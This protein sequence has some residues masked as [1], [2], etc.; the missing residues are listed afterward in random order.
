MEVDKPNDSVAGAAEEADVKAEAVKLNPVEDVVAAAAE[1][2]DDTA[3]DNPPKH[4][5]MDSTAGLLVAG[6]A[7]AARRPDFAPSAAVE[8]AAGKLNEEAGSV[9]AAVDAGAADVAADDPNNVEPPVELAVTAAVT[10]AVASVVLLVSLL[11]SSN[12]SFTRLAASSLS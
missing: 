11:S 5:P 7:N 3:V 1:V 12:I 4:G 10:V 8:V 6:V 2:V 9:V